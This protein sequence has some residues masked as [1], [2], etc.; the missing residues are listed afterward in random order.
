M[1]ARPFYLGSGP[2]WPLAA[3]GRARRA[4]GRPRTSGGCARWRLRFRC[5]S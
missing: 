1:P 4:T 3:A 5:R 2:E